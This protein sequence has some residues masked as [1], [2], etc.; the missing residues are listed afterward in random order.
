MVIT[1][2]KVFALVLIMLQPQPSGLP[3]SDIVVIDRL[4]EEDCMLQLH[5]RDTED[6]IGLWAC[7]L[8]YDF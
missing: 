8:D 1:T 7:T 2:T 5:N 6:T 4:S 3:K